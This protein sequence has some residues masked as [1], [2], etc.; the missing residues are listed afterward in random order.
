MKWSIRKLFRLWWN[1]IDWLS[2]LRKLAFGNSSSVTNFCRIDKHFSAY[3]NTAN[4]YFAFNDAN[5]DELFLKKLKPL[6]DVFL[7]IMKRRY[8]RK[9]KYFQDNQLNFEDI[10]IKNYHNVWFNPRA[11]GKVHLMGLQS[12][13]KSVQMFLID[14]KLKIKIFIIE[15]LSQITLVLFV[16]IAFYY[17]HLNNW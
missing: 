9:N 16:K 10:W 3:R 15:N 5:L 8:P 7:D 11:A 6:R 4:T 1:R 13:Y 14:K 17:W 12:A 2:R